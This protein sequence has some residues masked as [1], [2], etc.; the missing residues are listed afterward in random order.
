MRT[1]FRL[2]PLLS[3]LALALLT[4]SC[5]SGPGGDYGIASNV[6]A[7]KIDQKSRSALESL[8]RSHPGARSLAARSRA[9]LVFPDILKGGVILGGS[10]GDGTLYQRNRAAGFYRSISASYGLQIGLQKYGYALFLMDS[11][12]INSLNSSD[13]WEIG[14]TPNLVVIDQGAALHISS[15]TLEDG[16]YA[17]VFGQKGLMAGVSLEGTKVTRLAV[18]Q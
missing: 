17:V 15:T 12:A 11:A 1:L 4:V 10:Y 7:R 8:Y 2:F 9:I 16:I 6:D 13:G 18:K 3:G 14:S 5:A